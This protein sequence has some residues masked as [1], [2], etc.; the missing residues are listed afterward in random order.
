MAFFI[1]SSL[2]V[3]DLIVE[4][5][6]LAARHDNSLLN[7]PHYAKLVKDLENQ[8]RDGLTHEAFVMDGFPILSIVDILRKL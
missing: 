1:T 8:P 6:R 2:P 3:V 7:Q 4:A 5:T